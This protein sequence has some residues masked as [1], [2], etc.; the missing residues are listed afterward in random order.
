MFHAPKTIYGPALL[1][2]FVDELGGVKPVAKYLD[3]HA[4]TVRRWLS[5]EKVPRAVVLALFWE[6]QYGRSHINTDQVNEIQQLHQHLR[7]AQEQYRRA[8]DIVTGLRQLHAGSANEPLFD[9]LLELYEYPTPPYSLGTTS[10]HAASECGSSHQPHE[11]STTHEAG[12]PRL[13]ADAKKA[14]NQHPASKRVLAR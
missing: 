6:S 2:M 14:T 10:Y 7:L 9:E 8:K 5:D 11:A 1:R 13:P 4:R 12:M 3:V